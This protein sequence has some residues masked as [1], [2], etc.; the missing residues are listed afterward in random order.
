MQK[1]IVERAFTTHFVLPQTACAVPP[2]LCRHLSA[3]PA[4][5]L[6]LALKP[7]TLPA[8]ARGFMRDQLFRSSGHVVI[9]A[10]TTSSS[11]MLAAHCIH[12]SAIRLRRTSWTQL[13]GYP[14]LGCFILLAG[15]L[16]RIA[17]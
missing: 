4:R 13:A 14:C 12:T 2:T 3:T 17:G 11:S 1:P 10:M 9:D 8:A 16:G 5:F 7:G 15:Q 6:T